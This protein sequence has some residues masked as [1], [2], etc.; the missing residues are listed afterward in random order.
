MLQSF[1]K[2][3]TIVH[4][5]LTAGLGTIAIAIYAVCFTNP[6]KRKVEADYLKETPSVL[7]WIFL[8][9]LTTIMVLV[10]LVD[11]TVNG[12]GDADLF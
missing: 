9:A 4:A 7:I 6:A 10:G 3:F 5:L 1:L 8:G 2:S 12:Y 11:A